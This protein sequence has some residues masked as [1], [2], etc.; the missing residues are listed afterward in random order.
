MISQL[1]RDIRHAVR[2]LRR[3]PGFTVVAIATLAIGIGANVAIFSVVNG[4]LLEPL[5]FKDAERL[6]GLWHTAPG[7][8]YPQIP[9]SGDTYVQIRENNSV[10]EEVGLVTGGSAILTGDGDP[11]RVQAGLATHT[12]FPLLGVEAA[13]GRTFTAQ[14]DNPD[15]AD[16]V[17]LSHGL[18]ERRYGGD[19]GVVG[20]AIQID[21]APV[22]V[23]GVLPRSFEYMETDAAL[24]MPVDLDPANP[25]VGSFSFNGV[26]RLLPGRTAEVAEANL[27][28]LVERLLEANQDSENY[29]AFLENG[30]FGTLVHPLKEDLVGNASQPLYILLGTVGFVLLIACANVANLMIVRS[31]A[32]RREMAIRSALGAGRRVLARQFLA[33]SGVLAVAGGVLGLLLA[34]LGVPA[35]LSIA[36]DQLPRIGNV[37]LST[38]VLAFTSALVVLSVLLF[39]GLPM[40]RSLSSKGFGAP[41]SARGTTAGR[42]RHRLRNLLVAGQTALALILLVGSGLMI[43]S[44]NELRNVDPGFEPERVLTF[45]IALPPTRY[46]TAQGAAGF[47]QQLL[48]RLAALPGVETVGAADY[49]PMTGSGSGTAF[50][51]EDK[52]AGPGE[53]PPMLWYKYTAPGYFEA[54]GTRVLEGRVL[55]RSDHEQQLP[56]VVVNRATAERIW[57]GESAIGKRMAQANNDTTRLWYNVVGVVETVRDQG[58][59][60]EPRDL[61]YFPMVGPQ[62]DDAWTLLNMTYAVRTAGPPT[63]LAGPVRA[64]VWEMDSNLPVADLRPLADIVAQSTART[65]FTMMALGV[66]ALVALILGAIGLYGVV[67]YVVSER[68]REIGVRI[69]L[70]AESNEVLRM[71]VTQGVKLAVAG[72]IVGVVASLAMTRLMAGLLYGTSPTDPATFVVTSAVL[73]S[74]GIAASYLPARRAAT[75]DPVEPLRA[76]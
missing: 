61:V 67:S 48:E 22:E 71:V 62:G 72:L 25:P 13:I 45:G 17:V 31:D 30:Q 18:W 74:V 46:T 14:E 3:T 16:V 4:V 54:M 63:A 50:E 53:L 38:A 52:P 24:W 36:P 10:F 76:D 7:L 49:L 66:A 20:R 15:A 5:P 11:E 42:D 2:S 57:P 39:G 29:V 32:R 75:I 8:N 33:E 6:V 60:E 35:L 23:I 19:P 27:E 34:G 9:L 55:D 37:G 1:W 68:T 56:N 70:G 44:F 12:L 58:L 47:H 73:L 40:M 59:E 65:S 41:T 28:P 26:A 51:I 43:R 21:G 69:A 64:Q